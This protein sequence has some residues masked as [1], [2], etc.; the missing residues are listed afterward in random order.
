MKIIY[1]ERF[2]IK[3]WDI[4]DVVIIESDIVASNIHN[5]ISLSEEKLSL[6]ENL[7]SK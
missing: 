1:N 4:R 6:K 2:R 5:F 3:I 7:I